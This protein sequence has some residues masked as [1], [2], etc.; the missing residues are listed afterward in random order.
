M[1]MTMPNTHRKNFIP[2]SQFSRR[3]HCDDDEANHFRRV[4][5]LTLF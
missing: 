3:R 4:K 5:S 1:I 2:E